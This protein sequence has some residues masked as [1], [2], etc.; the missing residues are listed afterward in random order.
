MVDNNPGPLEPEFQDSAGLAQA[1]WGPATELAMSRER[2]EILHAIATDQPL[3]QVL[4]RLGRLTE[5][6]VPAAGFAVMLRPPNGAGLLTIGAGNLPPEFCA[7]FE[8]LL[9]KPRAANVVRAL[10]NT[11]AVELVTLASDPRWRVARPL[12]D[13]FGLRART[14]LPLHARDGRVLG[15]C[16]LFW[17]FDA[18]PF[19]QLLE[20]IR[21]VGHLVSIAV[22]RAAAQRELRRSEQRFRLLFANHPDAVFQFNDEGIFVDVNDSALAMVGYPRE[23][24]LGRHWRELLAPGV[25]SRVQGHFE[26]ALAGETQRYE[27]RVMHR[28]GHVLLLDVINQPVHED[29]RSVGVFGIARDITAHRRNEQGLQLLQRAVEVSGSGICIADARRPDMPLTYVNPAFE[30]ITGYSAAEVLGRNCRFLQ[31]PNPSERALEIMRHALANGEDAQVVLRNL[32]RDGSEFWNELHLS[33]IIDDA[34]HITHWLGVQNDVSARKRY[35][36]DLRH[37]AS[38]DALTGP[39][40]RTLLEDRIAQ[41]CQFAARHNHQL[42]VLFIDLDGF[43]PIN[44]SYGHHCGDLVLRAVASRVLAC[45]N[46]GDTVARLRALG[47]RTALDDFGQGYSSLAYVKQLPLDKLKIDRSFVRDVLVDPRDAAITQTVIAL[48]HWLNLQ[49]VAEGVETQAQFEFLRDR[50][51]DVFQGFLFAHPQPAHL[52]PATVGNIGL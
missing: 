35:E 28:D 48:G 11:K 14:T 29:E 50:G 15:A 20:L 27:V 19:A 47:V 37:H 42:A 22:E 18:P 4:S 44:D 9:N 13:R 31:A 3:P 5:A 7:A 25:H 43:K 36:D 12:T 16:V 33:P 6:R 2:R 38:H 21:P 49:V 24:V 39:P 46:R 26:K 1:A 52:L 34:G 40:N 17:R 32:R 45:V 8:A 51:C 10:L 23:Q 30:R 41:S